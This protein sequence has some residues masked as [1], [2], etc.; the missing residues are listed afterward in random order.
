MD[1]VRVRLLK[2][3]FG[4]VTDLINHRF[5]EF[6]FLH[7]LIWEVFYVSLSEQFIDYLT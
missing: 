3:I 4:Y 7:P 2:N 6:K 5:P 1:Y